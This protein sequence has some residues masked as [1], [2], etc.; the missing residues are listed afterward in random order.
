M[1]RNVAW[2]SACLE[3]GYVREDV[4]DCISLD[5]VV[6]PFHVETDRKLEQGKKGVAFTMDYHRQNCH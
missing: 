6:S 3:E 2:Q 5:K 1:A 4:A